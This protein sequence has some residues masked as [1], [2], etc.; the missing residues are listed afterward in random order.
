VKI[1]LVESSVGNGS[2]QQ[3]LA[4]YI[5]NDVVVIDAGSVGFVTPL[6][7]QKQIRHIFLS[8]SHIDHIASLP[9]FVDNT[10]EPGPDCVTVHGSPHTLNCL[11]TDIFND[12]VW[13]DMIR[14]SAEETP[15][16]KLSELTSATPVTV[17]DLTVTPIALDHVVPTLGFI[18]DDGQTAVAFVSDT[19]PTSAIWEA[20]N[21]TQRLRAVFLEASFPNDMEWLAAKAMHLTPRLFELELQKL[22]GDADI[23]AIH[24]KT[25]FDARIRKELEALSLPRMEI[26]EPG[27]TYEFH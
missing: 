25:A 13:P 23:I 12:R 15:F 16:L 10:Y 18:V 17:G 21:Q 26:G 14:L 5:V 8:H 9:V 27:R 24:I 20:I 11:R 4:S 7:I 2:H 3:I 19:S 1:T 6:E 22:Q